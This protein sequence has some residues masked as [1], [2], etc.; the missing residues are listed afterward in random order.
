M[1]G[2]AAATRLST[3]FGG[4]RIYIRKDAMADVAMIE[5]I[6]ERAARLLSAR[7]GGVHI[8]VPL[9]IGRRERILR[10]SREGATVSGIAAQ[11]HCSRRY[12]MQVRA[13]ARTASSSP[14]Y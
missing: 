2:D 4:R 1:I 8:E 14:S 9:R 6:G 5:R 10:L 3:E 7:F 13:E 11:L 12:V